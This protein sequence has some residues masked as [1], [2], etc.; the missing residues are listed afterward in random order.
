VG[1]GDSAVIT[2]LILESTEG[3]KN[4]EL[5]K[6]SFTGTEAKGKHNWGDYLKKSLKDEM[7]VLDCAE[8]LSPKVAVGGAGDNGFGLV[9]AGKARESGQET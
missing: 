9:A 2:H 8:Y 6:L 3:M 4:A 5:K 1:L 7:L